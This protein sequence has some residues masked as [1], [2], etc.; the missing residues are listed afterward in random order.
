MSFTD[1][2]EPPA[3]TASWYLVR[4][5]NCYAAGGYGFQSNGIP[6]LTNCYP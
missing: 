5:R 4:A 6:R 1:S 3:G 2:T